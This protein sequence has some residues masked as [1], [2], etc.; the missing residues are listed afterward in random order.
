MF[1]LGEEIVVWFSCGAASAVAAKKTL[2]KYGGRNRVR[3]VNNPVLEEHADNLRF[4]KDVETWLGVEIETAL[5]K[6]FPEHS[7]REVWAAR[8]FM[9][10]VHGAPC[11]LELKK[12]ARYQWEQ[13]NTA[14]WHVLGFTNEERG[15]HERFVL[16]ERTNVIPVLIDEKLS[17]QDCL[18]LLLSE[19]ISPPRMYSLGFPNAN[20]IGCVKATSP[21][22]WNLVRREFP[23]VFRDRSEQ[24]RDIGAKLARYK[25][26]R[27]FLD[28]LPAYAKGRALK[29]MSIECGIF[30]EE[31]DAPIKKKD[32][33]SLD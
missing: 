22:Y 24:S 26:R 4:L 17:K 21:S 31:K 12:E 3:I 30:C 15:R 2:E 10:G 33:L 28:E 25:G 23:S 19:G 7:A 14:D 29:N 9:S 5:N 32:W 11:T 8:R 16:S 18:N 27:I 6:K 20:C 13:T 1:I